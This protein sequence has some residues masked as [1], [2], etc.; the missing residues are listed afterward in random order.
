MDSYDGELSSE[1][2]VIMLVDTHGAPLYQIMPVIC[3][4][5][6]VLICFM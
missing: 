4:I 6:F 1:T 5:S 2:A 3:F